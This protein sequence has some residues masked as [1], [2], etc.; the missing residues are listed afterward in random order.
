VIPLFFLNEK[1]RIVDEECTLEIV[2]RGNM[3]KVR[4]LNIHYFPVMS[5][6]TYTE[7]YR[8]LGP[9]LPRKR[10]ICEKAFYSSPVFVQRDTI[11]ITI[12]LE[13]LS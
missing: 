1:K 9:I 2:F 10:K 7:I 3:E 8:S 11:V 6:H 5:V 13:K 12:Y 4:K